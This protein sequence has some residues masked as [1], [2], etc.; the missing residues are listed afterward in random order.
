MSTSSSSSSSAATSA[1]VQSAINER[2]GNKS[3]DDDSPN[4]DICKIKFASKIAYIRHLGTNE[5]R[6]SLRALD[7]IDKA[8]IFRH[9]GIAQAAT[10]AGTGTPNKLQQESSIPTGRYYCELCAFKADSTFNLAIHFG[11]Q[12]HMQNFSR[13]KF[14]IEPIT[15]SSSNNNSSDDDGEFLITKSMLTLNQIEVKKFSISKYH[16]NLCDTAS[17]SD[18]ALRRHLES[19]RHKNRLLSPTSGGVSKSHTISP[20]KSD[21]QLTPQ[22]RETLQATK[23]KYNN[24]AWCHV[25]YIKY[26]SAANRVEHLNGKEHLK[27]FFFKETMS[28]AN[29]L[30]CDVCFCAFN[31]HE[32]FTCHMRSPTHSEQVRKYDNYLKLMNET[33]TLD[34]AASPTQAKSSSSSSSSLSPMFK[35]NTFENFKDLKIKTTSPSSGKI[36][37]EDDD[38]QDEEDA[39]ESDF[40]NDQATMVIRS[41]K[42]KRC[43]F[44]CAHLNKIPNVYLL[45][46]LEDAEKKANDK[47][48]EELDRSN[49]MLYSELFKNIDSCL[50]KI[51]SDLTNK[52]A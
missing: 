25:C 51:Y 52:L 33:D 46:F 2:D 20:S 24:S 48:L 15:S 43:K 22:Q 19:D 37:E 12:L 21:V 42:F 27:K 7:K 9:L 31:S 1:F 35:S 26:S 36:K 8:P 41:D 18:I 6:D 34:G 45:D 38:D 23:D 3:S 30:F 13:A 50:N 32:Q 47:R 4:C 11:S 16:C 10:T 39:D 49:E 29:S 17:N 28:A 5:H 14:Q 44:V 40:S